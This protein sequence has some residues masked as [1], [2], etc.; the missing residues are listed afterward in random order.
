MK[1]LRSL[2]VF[3][4]VFALLGF[5]GCSDDDDDD[6]A[7]SSSTDYYE[8]METAFLAYTTSYSG[9]NPSADDVYARI[10][11]N[12]P[13]FIID[14]RAGTDYDAGHIAIDEINDAADQVSIQNWSIGDLDDH[15]ADLPAAGGD[16]WIVNVCYSGQSAS[17]ATAAM[18]LAGYSNA[19]NLLFG[20][21]GWTGGAPW[22]TLASLDATMEQTANTIP[23]TTY[24]APAREFDTDDYAE[25]VFTAFD[26]YLT[27]NEGTAN[28][29]NRAGDVDFSGYFVI[30]YWS[31]SEYLDGHI[32]GAYQVTPKEWTTAIIDQLPTDEPI[33]VYCYTGQTSS[34]LTAMLR[35]MGYDAYSLLF[36]MNNYNRSH[37]TFQNGHTF[38]GRTQTLPVT[39]D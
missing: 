25:A 21:S 8:A 39:G 2:T 20:M 36:G 29:D 12:E 18:R 13:T 1:L 22:S 31:E 14:W 32:P 34:Q 38:P 33:L 23:A 30:N 15:M 10:E 3:M 17:Q 35:I 16:T 37:P 7:G 28:V 24:D 5:A 11:A 26:N 4:L 27:T 9:V 6:P 19:K